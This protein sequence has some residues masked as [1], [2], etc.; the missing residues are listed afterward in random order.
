MVDSATVYGP[1]ESSSYAST[2][3]DIDGIEWG[4]LVGSTERFLNGDG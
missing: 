4:L 2:A 3:L 1:F